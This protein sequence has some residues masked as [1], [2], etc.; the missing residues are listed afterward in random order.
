M[1]VGQV[2][3]GC[4]QPCSYTVRDFTFDSSVPSP[5]HPTTMCLPRNATLS[6][7][8]TCRYRPYLNENG[9]VQ[10]ATYRTLGDVGIVTNCA[11]YRGFVNTKDIDFEECN[12]SKPTTSTQITGHGRVV[13]TEENET[14]LLAPVTV[15]RYPSSTVPIN[16]ALTSVPRLTPAAKRSTVSL[17]ASLPMTAG[18]DILAPTSSE[19]PGLTRA[20]ISRVQGNIN[21]PAV[22]HDP[23]LPQDDNDEKTES[24]MPNDLRNVMIGLLVATL[25]LLVLCVLVSVALCVRRRSA[26]KSG[27]NSTN[28]YRCI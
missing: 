6:V 18:A 17:R 26:K 1:I 15:D 2:L 3:A 7:R 11:G 25:V 22:A 23:R 13:G 9:R 28:R 27:A 8:L 10:L 19:F 21:S 24:Y 16:I 14:S 4:S 12:L 20:S 5:I